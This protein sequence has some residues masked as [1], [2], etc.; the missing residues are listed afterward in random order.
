MADHLRRGCGL[1]EEDEAQRIELGL[2]GFQSSARGD[3][4]RTIL[5]GGAQSFF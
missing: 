5:L 3:D 4:V 1:I 2:L